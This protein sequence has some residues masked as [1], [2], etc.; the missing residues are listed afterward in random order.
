MRR[1]EQ[2]T[3]RTLRE[4]DLELAELERAAYTSRLG[5]APSLIGRHVYCGPADMARDGIL[6]APAP[7]LH[8]HRLPEQCHI[9]ERLAVPPCLPVIGA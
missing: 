9:G 7:K 2:F 4:I 8:Q 5:I 3:G 1:S 6:V